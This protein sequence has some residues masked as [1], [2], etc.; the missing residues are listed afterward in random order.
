M[1]VGLSNLHTSCPLP[2]GRFLIIISVR[3]CVNPRAIERLEG[4]GELISN[5]LIRNQICNLRLEAQCPS[6]LCEH[7]PHHLRISHL[8][9]YAEYIL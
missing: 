2:S 4:L 3:R 9:P 5:D 7:V 6:Q 8:L 1:V